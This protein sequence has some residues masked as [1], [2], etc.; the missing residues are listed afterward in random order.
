LISGNFSIPAHNTIL[1][2]DSEN[3]RIKMGKSADIDCIEFRI[4]NLP[5]K[6]NPK[7]IKLFVPLKPKII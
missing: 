5:L 2:I 6:K 3:Q 4:Q 7:K 1:I